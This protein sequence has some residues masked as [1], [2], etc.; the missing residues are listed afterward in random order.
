MTQKIKIR[1]GVDIK[2]LGKPSDIVSVAKTSKTY[3]VQPP[4]YIGLIPKLKVKEGDPVQAG[5]TLFYDKKM[6]SVQ[7]SSPVSGTVKSIVRGAKR[8]VLAVIVEADS[9]NSQVDFGV[10]D[11]KSAS[12][13]DLLEKVLEGGMFPCFRQRPFDVVADPAES[14]RSI[15]ISGFDSSPLAGICAV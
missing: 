1:K 9:S 7:Y 4:D 3:A 5:T 10:I 13:E 8:R 2:L 15:F 12:R 11:T 14:P 6:E